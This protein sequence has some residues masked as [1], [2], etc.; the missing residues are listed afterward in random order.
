MNSANTNSA[1]RYVYGTFTQEELNRQYDAS[2]TV[3]AIEPFYARF[4]AASALALTGLRAELDVP[5]G[6]G[7]RHR[8]DLFP[9]QRPGAPLFFFIHGGYWR[10]LDKSFFSFLAQ[11]VVRAGG[12]VAIVNYPLAPNAS[13]DEI[14]DSVRAGYTWVAANA[15]R[16]NADPARIVAGGHSAGGHLAGMLAGSQFP[17]AGVLALSGLFDL[18]PVRLSHVNEWAKLDARSAERNSPIRRLPDAPLPLVAA[19]GQD[20]TDEFRRQ[21]QHYAEVWRAR[22]YPAE[23]LI[24]PGHNHFTIVLELADES[25]VLSQALAELLFD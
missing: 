6:P 2:A 22:R 15:A 10:R 25:T 13:I 11:P 20:E 7:D 4:A 5:Y 24:L 23:E 18:E 21:T 9:A 14:V 3:P 16:L 19:V 1:A 17:L 8:L 12:A